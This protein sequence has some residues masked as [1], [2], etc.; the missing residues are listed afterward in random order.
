MYVHELYELGTAQVDTMISIRSNNSESLIC[1]IQ[2]HGNFF[3]LVTSIE[4]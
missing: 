4:A 2:H 3:T 1:K